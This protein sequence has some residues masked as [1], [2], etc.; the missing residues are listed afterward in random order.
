MIDAIA[1]GMNHTMFI[2]AISLGVG[3]I[4]GV[5]ANAAICP[6]AGTH[7]IRTVAIV[8]SFSPNQSCE[9]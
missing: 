2:S 7:D 4:K 1:A 6:R 9:T 3:T 5:N 8:R